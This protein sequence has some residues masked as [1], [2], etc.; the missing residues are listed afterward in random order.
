MQVVANDSAGSLSLLGT[1]CHCRFWRIII[2]IFGGKRSIALQHG[3]VLVNNATVA[4]QH[5]INLL[6]YSIEAKQNC[7]SYHHG[8]EQGGEN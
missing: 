2:R 1:A 5:D 4:V 7:A 3:N 8:I 6:L